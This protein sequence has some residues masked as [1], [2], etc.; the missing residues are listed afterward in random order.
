MV[1]SGTP[2]ASQGR[3]AAEPSSTTTFRGSSV[4]RGGT[5]SQMWV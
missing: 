3:T 2:T 5:G 1:G 4:M